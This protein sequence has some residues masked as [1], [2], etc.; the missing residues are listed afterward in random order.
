MLSLHIRHPFAAHG[1]G[2]GELGAAFLR[3]WGADIWENCCSQGDL[4]CSALR[5]ACLGE[6]R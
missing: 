6:T 1:F 4:W 2:A 5:Q 3:G